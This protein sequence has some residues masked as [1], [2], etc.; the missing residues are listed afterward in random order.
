MEFCVHLNH[1]ENMYGRGSGMIS[2][3]GSF[4]RDMRYVGVPGIDNL[5]QIKPGTIADFPKI[6]AS[7]AHLNGHPQAWEEEGGGTGADGKFVADYN[8]VRGVN[9]NNIRG[10]NA[11]GGS[12]IGHYVSRAQLL[13]ALGRPAAQVLYFHPTDSMWMGD[14]ESD[15]VLTRPANNVVTQL[16][17][18][19]IDFD[20]VDSDDLV[21]LLT[22]EKGGLK[23]LSGQVYK[24]V[25]YPISTVI[26]KPVLERLKAFAAGGG[27]VVFVGRTPNMLVDQSFL[28]AGGPPDLSF[29]TLEPSGNITPRVLAALPPPDVKLDTPCP[30]IKYN[31]RAYK[32][33]DVYFFFNESKQSETRTVTLVGTGDV[34]VWDPSTG[35]INPLANAPK[36]AG[37]VAV[38]LTL[39]GQATRFI[40]IG[41]LPPGAGEPV[42]AAGSTGSTGS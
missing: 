37:S 32:D 9:F 11:A 19:Q 26:T 8:L 4:W 1:E 5:S 3:E 38:P 29:A 41:P 10:M 13:L 18:H 2:N 17:E 15:D 12:E 36:A 25:V 35:K 6:A 42:A 7:A 31:H 20:H 21:S 33:G 14:T 24:G 27:K 34:Q 23:N 22:L 28:H 40:V 30:A 39:A 16:L